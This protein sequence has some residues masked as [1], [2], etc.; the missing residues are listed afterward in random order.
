MVPAKAVDELYLKHAVRPEPCRY[1][2]SYSAGRTRFRK[3]KGQIIIPTNEHARLIGGLK[4]VN[5]I[6]N[7][8]YLLTKNFKSCYATL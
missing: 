8:I 3:G 2:K 1:S 4:G 5:N 7:N 6:L